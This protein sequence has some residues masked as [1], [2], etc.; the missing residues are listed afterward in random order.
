[1]INTV[2][3]KINE[4]RGHRS[5]IPYSTSRNSPGICYHSLFGRLIKSLDG[6]P[7][8]K[9]FQGGTLFSY[10]GLN[11]SHLPINSSSFI[12]IPGVPEVEIYSM[13]LFHFFSSIFVY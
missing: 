2:N 1:M 5:Y 12:S 10:L 3:R 13:S 11:M 6:N 7:L 8:K 4:M 9:K